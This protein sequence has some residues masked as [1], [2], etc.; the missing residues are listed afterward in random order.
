M[1][2]KVRKRTSR[3]TKNEKKEANL[4]NTVGCCI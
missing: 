3:D 1:T 4:F 2:S